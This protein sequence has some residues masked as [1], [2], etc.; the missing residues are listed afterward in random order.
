MPDTPLTVCEATTASVAMRTF[1]RHHQRREKR[2]TGELLCPTV[3]LKLGC[4]V[5]QAAGERMG[6]RCLAAPGQ[7]GH[8]S[9]PGVGGAVG[10]GARCSNHSSSL[11]G[12][13]RGFCGCFRLTAP[14]ELT[15]SS[16]ASP[17]QATRCW[18]TCPRSTR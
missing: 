18:C 13:L 10:V 5:A 1:C 16:K 12:P 15:D 11:A 7:G 6:I 17:V 3:L 2:R 4:L 8:L 9:A 14:A